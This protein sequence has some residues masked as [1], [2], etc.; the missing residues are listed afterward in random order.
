MIEPIP[1]DKKIN[2]ERLDAVPGIDEKIFYFRGCTEKAYPGIN[3][4]FVELCH[5]WG[6]EIISSNKQSCCT[7]NFLAFN[8]A[9]L[10]ATEAFT[11]R[12]YNIIKEHSNACIT[13]CNGCFS[14][15]H[16]MDAYIKGRKSLKKE[17]KTLLEKVNMDYVTD[18]EVFHVA[19]FLYKNRH[20]LV[21]YLK[22]NLENINIAV[23]YGC[24]FLHQE[25]ASVIIDDVE[26]P[27][28]IEDVLK[29]LRAN[30]V[31]YSEK[32]LCCGAGLNQRILQE[33]R[34]NSLRI[35][36]RKMESIARHEPDVIVVVCPY[37]LLHLDNAQVELEVEFDKEFEIPVVHLTELL[38][39]LLQLSPDTLRLDA[40][41]V[42][43]TGLLE[44]IG[45]N[46]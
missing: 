43:V 24:H 25:D 32:N 34:I 17:V 3:N 38:G 33:D 37:C 6:Q 7:G 28:I 45:Y 26:R 40:H 4:A 8:T 16:N 30:I 46:A 22:L 23:H 18:V 42:P 20:E 31:D 27:T 41:K 44:K 14:S 29:E 2:K 19:E 15:F 11:Q 5:A 1:V 13:T 9:P 36:L 21:K 10:L 35:T 39:I 12:N